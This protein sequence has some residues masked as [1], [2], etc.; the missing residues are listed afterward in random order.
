VLLLGRGPELW[1]WGGLARNGFR[2][3]GRLRVSVA[4]ALAQRYG[5]PGLRAISWL[6][7]GRRTVSPCVR[8]GKLAKLQANNSLKAGLVLLVAG[9]ALR[10]LMSGKDRRTRAR[11]ICTGT[12][13]RR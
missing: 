13:W 11:F 10:A 12:S 4:F 1:S 5:L 2:E 8:L 7:L 3:V 9:I 6:E